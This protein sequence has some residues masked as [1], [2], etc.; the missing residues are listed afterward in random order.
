MHSS[1]SGNVDYVKTH[2]KQMTNYFCLFHSDLWNAQTALL[3]LPPRKRK[4]QMRTHIQVNSSNKVCVN[5]DIRSGW[6]PSKVLR[7][8]EGWRRRGSL[9]LFMLSIGESHLLR[10]GPQCAGDTRDIVRDSPCPWRTYSS[11]IQDLSSVQ[12]LCWD[13]CP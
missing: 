11:K 10:S 6:Q 3:K 1:L 12:L 8:G 4:Q 2:Y 7:F 13:H 9:M 5:S